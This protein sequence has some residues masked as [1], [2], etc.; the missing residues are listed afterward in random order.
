M[1][2]IL[3]IEPDRRQASKVTTLAQ[4]LGVEL[5]IG[6]STEEALGALGT[7]VPDLVLTSQLLAP[8]DESALSERLRAL[9]AA[10]MHA[11]TLVIP[12]LS[13]EEREQKK[14]GG[15]F[16]RLRRTS[17]E[18]APDESDGC[19]PAVFG[20][21]VMD[22]LERVAAERAALAAAQADLDAAWAD[23]APSVSAQVDDTDE[24]P[25]LAIDVHPEMVIEDPH[26]MFGE[27]AAIPI[28]RLGETPLTTSLMEP[29]IEIASAADEAFD[30]EWPPATPPWTPPSPAPADE[31]WEE[32]ALD[33][34]GKSGQ[35][36]VSSAGE[37][38]EHMD[39]S[40]GHHVDVAS[41]SMD[42]D[43]FVRELHTVQ[44]TANAEPMIP[45]VDLTH[46]SGRD[47]ATDE[48]HPADIDVCL[49]GPVAVTEMELREEAPATFEAEVTAASASEAEFVEDHSEQPTPVALGAELAPPAPATLVPDYLD[50]ALAAFSPAIEAAQRSR[51][52]TW[53]PP[54]ETWRA[55]LDALPPPPAPAMHAVASAVEEAP[56]PQAPAFGAKWGDVLSS[57]RRDIDQRRAAEGAQAAVVKPKADVATPPLVFPTRTVAPSV[58]AAIESGAAERV[59]PTPL[60][61]AA[62]PAPDVVQPDR[63]L[64][65][66][67]DTV[68]TAE[69]LRAQ[70]A[71]EKTPT[72]SAVLVQPTATLPV[73][74]PTTTVEAI[75]AEAALE[76]T[77]VDEPAAAIET[78][79]PVVT[80]EPSDVVLA[81]EDGGEPTAPAADPLAWLT[82]ATA[83]TAAV[84]SVPVSTPAEATAPV[85]TDWTARSPKNKKKRR[86]QKTEAP[87]QVV[88]QTIGDWGFFDPQATGFG[89]LVARLNQLSGGREALPRG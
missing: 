11:Q 84:E 14:K 9:D 47:H 69:S 57:M 43:A 24:V 71:V 34:D 63:A 76:A 52:R 31:E 66:L 21:E 61:V 87:P 54:A 6:A 13:G 22:Y 29:T 50:A 79:P 55:E 17:Q 35:R 2:L 27:F 20:K 38:V 68:S 8:K 37:G 26:A 41:D 44:S 88:R 33:V 5:V 72:E 70:H 60:V 67:L 73:P 46:V 1:S 48:S 7:R 64:A 89:P 19:D 51:S 62:Q 10:G 15:L 45:V 42:L 49:P 23:S 56:Q 18:H 25:A 85:R 80:V 82:A 12:V 78:L 81:A 53:E 59:R 16:G 3:A 86:H 36:P 30:D 40:G 39:M 75:T 65:A 83:P 28:R 58:I 74:V 4:T 32:I 77:G